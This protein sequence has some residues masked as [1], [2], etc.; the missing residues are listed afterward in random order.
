VRA[1]SILVYSQTAIMSDPSPG[2][3]RKRRADRRFARVSTSI[4]GELRGRTSHGVEVMDLSAGGCLV[5]SSHRPE[6]GTIFDLRCEIG[7]EAFVAKA[8]VREASLDGEAEG[9]SYL[10]GLEFLSLS[11]NDQDLLLQFLARASRRGSGG[12]R[13]PS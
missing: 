8:R 9:P 10:V 6:P 13:P 1:G 2:P 7:V 4:A 3:S 12:A 11:A 5:R